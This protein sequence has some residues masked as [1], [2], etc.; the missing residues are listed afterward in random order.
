[1]G[2]G[3]YTCG[4]PGKFGVGP[5]AFGS[6][7]TTTALGGSAVFAGGGVGLAGLVHFVGSVPCAF[8]CLVM[9]S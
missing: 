9:A 4:V 6:F 5:C 1:M 2:V 7:G 3:T 8:D